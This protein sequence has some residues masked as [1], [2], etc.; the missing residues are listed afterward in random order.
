MSIDRRQHRRTR[1]RLAHVLLSIATLSLTVAAGGAVLHSQS[2]PVAAAEAAYSIWPSSTVPAHP[3]AGDTSKVTVGVQFSSSVMGTVNGIRFYRSALNQGPHT[4]QL[5]NAAGQLLSTVSF[6]ASSGSGWQTATFAQPIKIAASAKYV[7][8]YTAPHGK[9]AADP[10]GLVP[11]K[12]KVTK[13]LTA[14]QGVYNYGSTVPRQNWNNANYYVDVVFAPGSAA[15]PTPTPAPTP[16]PTPAPTSTPGVRNCATNPSSC[17]YPDASNTGVPA[18]TLLTRV[19]GQATSGPGWHWDTRGWLVVDGANTV[20]SGIE[21]ACTVDVSAD[22]VTVKNSKIS[23]TGE[24]FGIAI[25]HANNVTLVNNDIPGSQTPASRLLVNVK[26]IYGDAQN[27]QVLRNDISG[28]STGVQMDQGLIQDN[29][30]HALTMKSGDHINGTTSNGGSK[31]L[32]IQ[33]NTVFNSYGQTD[34]I[35]LFEDFGVQANRLINNNLVAGGGYTIYG[36]QNAGGPNTSNI[37]I[38]NNRFSKAYFPNSGSYG[39]IAAF[40]LSDQ[41]NVWSG[42][43]WDDSGATLNP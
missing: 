37:K 38:T 23:V 22:G 7:A 39:P 9:Y 17:G 29:Y 34:A 3:A 27:L 35:S 18:G 5:W 10:G 6:S 16:T 20:L 1:T 2:S 25:R 30:I 21:C 36:G 19:P 13:A 28:S 26:D 40:D 14:W 32:T 42:N 33:H 31:Q 15:T 12:P 4:G 41:G 11:T 8:S 43:V 24:T